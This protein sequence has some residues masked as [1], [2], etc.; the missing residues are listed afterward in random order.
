[1]R[2]LELQLLSHLGLWVN[3]EKSK[4]FPVQSTFFFSMELNSRARMRWHTAG[5]GVTQDPKDGHDL[6]PAT[7]SM[8]PV[9]LASEWDVAVIDTITQARA[10]STKQAYAL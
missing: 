8:E 7:R 1:Y 5:P 2:D 9:C 6:A 3:W 4:L 10:L